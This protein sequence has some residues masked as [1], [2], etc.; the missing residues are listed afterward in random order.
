MNKIYIY[1][2]IHTHI[3]KFP[4]MRLL[5]LCGEVPDRG[6]SEVTK[7]PVTVSTPTDQV[8][9]LHRR[10]NRPVTLGGLI[11][12]PDTHT[13]L[14]R[15][16]HGDDPTVP[17]LPSRSY[18]SSIPGCIPYCGSPPRCG[19][20]VVSPSLFSFSHLRYTVDWSVEDLNKHS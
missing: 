3:H 15:L 5:G 8:Y 20:P 12:T 9:C 4:T 19:L 18:F 1:T 16:C 14:Y 6:P 17:S 11:V 2:H 13:T 10:T 7:T